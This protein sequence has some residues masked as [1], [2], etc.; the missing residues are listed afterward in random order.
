[1]WRE[2]RSEIL[3][4]VESNKVYVYLGQDKILIILVYLLEPSNNFT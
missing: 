1:M 2:G 4:H 3:L